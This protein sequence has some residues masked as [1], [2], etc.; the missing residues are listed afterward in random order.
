MATNTVIQKK[1]L[2]EIYNKVKSKAD[3]PYNKEEHRDKTR[4]KLASWFVVG[5]FFVI[6]LLILFIPIYNAVVSRFIDPNLV[7]KFQETFTGVS[8]SIVGLLGFV[9]GFY[10][11]E[12]DK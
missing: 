9:L 12:G 1:L 11:K 5:Y 6:S 7:L 2:E 4:S 3:E 8:S 10:F